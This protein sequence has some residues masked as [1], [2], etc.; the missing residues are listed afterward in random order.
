MSAAPKLPVERISEMLRAAIEHRKWHEAR[1]MSGEHIA[2]YVGLKHATAVT[3]AE[4]E[5]VCQQ[6]IDVATANDLNERHVA[7]LEKRLHMTETL[8]AQ[9][10]ARLAG[11]EP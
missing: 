8:L 2:A 11:D 6:A 1:G 10:R 7:D 5:A 4:L 9:A 3:L